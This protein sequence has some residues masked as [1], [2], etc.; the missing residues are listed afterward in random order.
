MM[1]TN[2]DFYKNLRWDATIFEVFSLEERILTTLEH[3]GCMAASPCGLLYSV[4]NI[5]QFVGFAASLR[6]PSGSIAGLSG[7]KI[8]EKTCL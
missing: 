8:R 5:F 6:S 4:V 7:Q 3:S 1:G 2:P